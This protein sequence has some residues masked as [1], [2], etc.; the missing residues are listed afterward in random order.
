M[1][2]ER[3]NVRVAGPPDVEES[4]IGGR[5]A[6]ELEPERQPPP[7]VCQPSASVAG[8]EEGVVRLD[9]DILGREDWGYWLLDSL[10]K[11]NFLCRHMPT[12]VADP[13]QAC[14]RTSLGADLDLHTRHLQH[15]LA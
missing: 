11:S 1:K 2:A 9:Q 5:Y 10:K 8:C 13:F 7:T 12:D 3:S 15:A 4:E 14:K 6:V